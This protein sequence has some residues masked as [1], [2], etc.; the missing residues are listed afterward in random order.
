MSYLLRIQ[1]PPKTMGKNP[2]LVMEKLI[3]GMTT[4]A[5]SYNLPMADGGAWVNTTNRMLEQSVASAT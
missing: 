4:Q 2:Y 5:S 3:R 1:A